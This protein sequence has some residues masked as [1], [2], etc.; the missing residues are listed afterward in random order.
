MVEVVLFDLFETL[1]TESETRPTPAASLGPRL[2][3]DLA[4]YEVE[5]RRRRLSIVTGRSTFVETL[6][7][8]SRELGSAPDAALLEQVQRERVA[9]KARALAAIPA[10]VSSVLDE[11]LRRGKRIGVIS[12]CIAEDVV[13]WAS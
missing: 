9:V 7:E 10:R 13:T 3:L 1:I 11:L 6:A 8:I 5:W 2:G 4:D 12:N